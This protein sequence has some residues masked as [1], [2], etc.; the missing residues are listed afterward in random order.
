MGYN[1]TASGTAFKGSSRSTQTGYQNNSGGT[2]DMATPVSLNPSGQLI[3]VDVTSESNVKALVGITAQSI[4]N[5]ANGQV[6]DCGRLENVTTS[7]VIGDALYIAHNGI[8]TNVKPLIGSNSF[9]AGNWVVFMGVVVINEFNPLN[10]DI[11]L[12]MQVVGTL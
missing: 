1:P 2:L 4:P 3:S 6:I 8:L 11:K 9:T 10:K 12:M 5:S 7:F